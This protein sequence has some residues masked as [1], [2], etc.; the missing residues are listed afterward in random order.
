M[1][2]TISKSFPATLER[3]RS[4]LGWVIIHI[5]FDAAKLWGK[6]GHIK[7]KGEVNGFAFR[8]SLF[9]TGKGGHYLLV[10]KRMQKG[11]KV[12]AGQVAQFRLE[13]DTEERKVTFPTELKRALAEDA[14]IQHYFEQLSYSIRKWICDWVAEVKSP[15][16][17]VRR[18]EQ[19]AERL[20]ATMEAEHELPPVLKI[21]FARNPRAG[22][23]WQRMSDTQRRQH[24]L[25]I[26]Y[27]RSP[28]ARDRRIAKMLEEAETY[29]EKR[30]RAGAS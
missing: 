2:K 26:F 19:I 14:G 21:A 6:R 4:N 24:L 8:N 12:R 11:G 27:Y 29:A 10:N 7:I 17:R 3:M 16:A 25:G 13:P 1:A 23:G 9:P 18:A 20:L 5:P 15:D 30:R 28:E 22:E